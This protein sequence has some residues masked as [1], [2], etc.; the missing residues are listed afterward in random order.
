MVSDAGS[1][2][3]SDSDDDS[4]K[5]NDSDNS[6]RSEAGDED[7]T[8]EGNAN[9]GGAGEP[10]AQRHCNST[11]G[12]EVGARPAELPRAV[13]TLTQRPVLSEMF[14]HDGALFAD[15]A[16]FN[17]IFSARCIA[18][19]KYHVPTNGDGLHQFLIAEFKRA[20][21][22]N[23]LTNLIAQLLK[24]LVNSST[25]EVEI[26]IELPQL[27]HGC[28]QHKLQLYDRN[29]VV[30]QSDRL[31]LFEG[32]QFF[33][34]AVGSD[35]PASL[36]TKLSKRDPTAAGTARLH[37]KWPAA[38]LLIQ[39]GPNSEPTITL[40]H[41]F[42]Q[43][44]TITAPPA[45]LGLLNPAQ[46]LW[47]TTNKYR[48][49]WANGDLPRQQHDPIEL[50]T[51]RCIAANVGGDTD[52]PSTLWAE[53]LKICS[54][55]CFRSCGPEKPKGV[56]FEVSSCN[57]NGVWTEDTNRAKYNALSSRVQ[58]NIEQLPRSPMFEPMVKILD[59][60]GQL[61]RVR[62]SVFLKRCEVDESVKKVEDITLKMVCSE[63][64]DFC[65]NL[66]MLG[67]HKNFTEAW[68]TFA[69]LVQDHGYVYDDRC[70][71]NFAD[72]WCYEVLTRT[73][74]RIKPDD[75]AKRCITYPY[76]VWDDELHIRL[77]AF[78]KELYPDPAVRKFLM[79]ELA[80]CLHMKQISPKV[81]L[82]FGMGGGGKGTYTRLLLKVFEKCYGLQ[83]K[84]ELLTKSKNGGG[85]GASSGAAQLDG[86]LLVVSHEVPGFDEDL[87]KSW[88]GSDD[89][90]VRPLY[91]DPKQ[92]K[93]SANLLILTFNDMIK[94][95]KD[96]GMDRRILAIKIEGMY[97]DYANEKEAN[98]K[99]S[100]RSESEHAM[101][102]E[103]QESIMALAPQLM[104]E[105]ISI[106]QRGEFL[107]PPYAVEQWVAEVWAEAV[108]VNI[109][110]A[111]ME[112]WYTRCDCQPRDPE[113]DSN[114]ADLINGKQESCKHTVKGADI[115][116]KLKKTKLDNGEMLYQAAKGR[117]K[118]DDPVHKLLQKVRLGEPALLLAHKKKH[119]GRDNVYFGL[120][121]HCL[122]LGR[123]LPVQATVQT[124][125]Q[126]NTEG[127]DNTPPNV[128]PTPGYRSRVSATEH[129]GVIS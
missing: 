32:I 17:R 119:D 101:W 109:L 93:A 121:Q 62:Q 1:N 43:K 57:A 63:L 42:D 36:T 20:V 37:L 128:R 84:A 124:E 53:L 106:H 16:T 122:T 19:K 77:W 68:Y 39:V 45:F 98:E 100:E 108:A 78:L 38:E 60:E 40:S 9:E 99:K 76:P 21:D 115:I 12:Q 7:D 13:D 72:G 97:I 59:D 24:D 110:Q 14:A 29:A 4:D 25:G 55:G 30:V 18:G 94:L 61:K 91:K 46:W 66:D 125:C 104:A 35:I 65:S 22:A 31:C 117:A 88:W 73:K 107:E 86:K 49:E 111:P 69:E 102:P 33:Y 67:V 27:Y 51:L 120:K 56:A 127:M 5:D 89:I 54:N 112:K 129:C 113:T 47:R 114:T 34:V 96:A 70:Q 79:S 85:E 71:V 15:D 95:K 116:A 82:L 3:S 52:K 6:D 26:S 75:G 90:S 83:V 58:K 11:R 64:K 2:T 44:Q 50:I 23:A 41:G 105:L 8:D 74:R 48:R 103:K 28:F 123:P 92:I 118:S 81:L 10:A 126:V 87:V 80:K